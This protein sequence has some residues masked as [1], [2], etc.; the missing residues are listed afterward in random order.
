MVKA[1]GLCVFIITLRSATITFLIDA[2]PDA[3]FKIYEK[4]HL[5]M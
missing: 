2:T 5:L 3:F 1:I 4:S